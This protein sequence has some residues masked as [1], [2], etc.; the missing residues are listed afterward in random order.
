[1][2]VALGV[3]GMSIGAPA[4]GAAAGTPDRA[5]DA[6]A[7]SQIPPSDPE[8]ML[9][10]PAV[11][12]Y[13]IASM[14]VD[15]QFW[16]LFD[17]SVPSK[18]RRHHAL[19]VAADGVPIARL[20]V[21]ATTGRE[22]AIDT[23]VEQ[24][25][26]QPV[27]LP[28]DA[29]ATDDGV[30]VVAN[31]AAP[32]WTEMEGAAVITAVQEIDGNVQ[33][34]W[35]AD[36]LVWIVRGKRDAEEYVRALLRLQVATLDPFDQQGLTGDLFD[37]TPSVPGFRYWDLPRTNTAPNLPFNWLGDC[38]ERFYLGYVL[39]DGAA[40]TR[41]DPDDLEIALV[42]AAGRCV[43]G[44]LLAAVAADLASRPG[45]HAEQLGGWTVMVDEHI[46]AALVD[47]VVVVLASADPQTFVD[48]APFIEAFFAGL[49]R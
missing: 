32:V 12:G 36:E 9:R 48:M 13:S 31:S 21:A 11:D 4:R 42:K 45:A 16:M 20:V 25:F 39:P 27:F 47:D 26:A 8:L 19:V 7:A 23:Y 33:W 40:E 3:A 35:G 14:P 28:V 43:D 37:Y 18:F 10:I 38:A 49:P 2:A 44:G 46:M 29:E 30:V 6:M 17:E 5:P 22:P 41:K 34:A 1:L 15:D 24:V